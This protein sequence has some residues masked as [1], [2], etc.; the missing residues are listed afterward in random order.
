MTEMIKL[1]AIFLL[2]VLVLKFTRALPWAIGLASVAVILL[3]R[4]DIPV[5]LKIAGKSVISRLTITT[6][7]AF[8]F[9][10]FLQRML[11]RK[12]K[13]NRAHEALNRIFN[14][15]RINASLAPMMIG[16][17]P[18]AGVINICGQIV[19]KATDKY[20]N[21]EEKAFVTTYYRHVA[22]SFLPTF[23][24]VIIG[25][26][27]AGFSLTACLVGMIPIVILII[28]SGFVF[29]LRKVPKSTGTVAS[30]NKAKE[31]LAFFQSLWP[32]FL[33]VIL[34]IVFKLP[35]FLPVMGMAIV[36]IF[37]N[38]LTLPELKAMIVSAFEKR[39]L[40]TTVFIMIFKDLL[41]EANVISILPEMF[42]RLPLPSFIIYM[43]IVFFGAIISGQQ[44]INVVVFPIVFMAGSRQDLPLFLLLMASGY[45][46]MQV[47]PTHICLAYVT[48]YF[49][50]SFGGVVK[51][52][53]PVIMP[54]LVLACLYYLLLKYVLML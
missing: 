5:A 17:L 44:A 24:S 48:E 37:I 13:L 34:V 16:M 18:S 29:Y 33:I 53:I 38:H 6:L 9:I 50:V 54:I 52:T 36:S 45:C 14:N 27:L 43:L 22:E 7:L 4:L 42:G 32:L 11:E 47:S 23:P 49:K 3:F 12:G 41:I 1:A 46:A 10:T 25:A 51:K 8:Y 40:F 20:L 26:N 19:D 35:V 31:V 15:R 28:G 30:E 2:M 39:M 21:V